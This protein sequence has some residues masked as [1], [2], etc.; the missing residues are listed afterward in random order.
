MGRVGFG[1]C[2]WF[3]LGSK[4]LGHIKSGYYADFT[5]VNKNLYQFSFEGLTTIIAGKRD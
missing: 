4:R 2:R 3:V 5:I 1:A